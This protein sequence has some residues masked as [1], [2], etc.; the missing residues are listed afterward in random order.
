M[1]SCFKIYHVENPGACRG[2]LDGGGIKKRRQQVSNPPP[3][4]PDAG[5]F[6]TIISSNRFER[7]ASVDLD[8][9][10]TGPCI[11]KARLRS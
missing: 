10:A 2:L 6:Q 3:R 4:G 9:L 1:S 5:S 11:L 7:L 8:H